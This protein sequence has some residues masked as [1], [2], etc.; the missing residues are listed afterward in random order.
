MLRN[1]PPDGRSIIQVALDRV[2]HLVS[3]FPEA[4][5]KVLIA[6]SADSLVGGWIRGGYGLAPNKGMVGHQGQ[7]APWMSL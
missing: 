2:G 1:P 3:M 4:H 7:E 5:V 6:G